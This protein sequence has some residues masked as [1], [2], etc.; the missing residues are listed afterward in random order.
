MQK[1]FRDPTTAKAVS[2]LILSN[3]E[4]AKFLNFEKKQN[5]YDLINVAAILRWSE[6]STIN[7]DARMIKKMNQWIGVRD[8]E[9]ASQIIKSIL[10]PKNMSNPEIQPILLKALKKISNTK[11][12]SG[13]YEQR[14]S[15]LLFDAFMKPGVAEHPFATKIGQQLT[16]SWTHSPAWDFTSFLRRLSKEPV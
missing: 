4:N 16:E 10:N 12:G 1:L 14:S 15:Q 2:D 13:G 5:Y 8:N 6:D 7:S 9:M 11:P 3:K